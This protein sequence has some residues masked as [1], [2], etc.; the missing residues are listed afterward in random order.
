MKTPSH[1]MPS[2]SVLLLL[3]SALTPDGGLIDGVG[4][5][6]Q[7]KH[8]CQWGQNLYLD[9]PGRPVQIFWHTLSPRT[10]LKSGGQVR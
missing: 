4:A 3:T 2:M 7:E 5:L 9:N 6:S 8:H 10:C 1:V